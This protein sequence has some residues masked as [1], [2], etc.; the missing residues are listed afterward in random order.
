MVDQPTPLPE[1]LAE[2]E[3]ADPRTIGPFEVIG[4][5]GAGGMGVVYGALDGTG[6]CV[7]VKVIHP[8]FAEQAEYR[9]RFEREVDLLR[10]L[11][12]ECV[13]AFLGADPHAEQPWMATEFVPGHT[14]S[15][16]VRE[17]G[18]LAGP[19][20]HAFAAG[21]A[22][23]IGA[24]HDADVIH[25][26]IKPGN[27]ILSPDGPKIL[28][29]GIARGATESTPEQGVHGTPGYLPPERLAGE[30]SSTAGDV[31]AWGGMVAFAATGRPP[32]GRGE[33]QDVLR[34][35]R[36]GQYDL[37]GV[38][39]DLRE[40][41]ER[42][43]SGDAVDRPTAVECFRESLRMAAPTVEV[44]SV[45]EIDTVPATQ[46]ERGRLVTTLARAWTGFDAAGHDPRAWAALGS[47][48]AA[49]GATAGLT[50]LMRGGVPLKGGPVAASPPAAT[51]SGG[52]AGGQI[53]GMTGAGGTATGIS[54]GAKVAIGVGSIVAAGPGD[55]RLRSRVRRRRRGAGRGRPRAGGPRP[56]RGRGRRG[57][58]R[59]RGH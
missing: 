52:A 17:F 48:V 32:F 39:D 7:A 27:V 10:G 25:R 30:P 47:G 51:A 12:A 19:T 53:G 35:V 5:L 20:L 11:D 54:L 43:L 8:E 42:A 34:R 24:I 28:D 33:T 45:D 55:R 49:A 29:F 46:E 16:H 13:P 4:R 2:L 6:Q 59:W 26:D 37:T 22:E 58:R 38:P 57:L 21:T 36:S 15:E 1:E 40:L 9:E 50:A 44:L 23:A 18:P 14:L 56:G 3:E 31:F 41:V